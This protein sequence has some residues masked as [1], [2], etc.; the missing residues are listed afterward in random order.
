MNGRVTVLVCGDTMRGD[1]GLGIRA[2]AR[3]PAATS[4][5]AEIREIGQLSP[6]DL[7]DATGPVI[8][9]DAV[10]G[11]PPGEL[12]DMPLVELAGSA[13]HP[14]SP[15]THAL[16][17]ATAV[18]LCMQLRGAVPPGRFL[19]LAGADFGIGA[20]LSDTVTEA[21]PQLTT[22]IERWIGA[23]AHPAALAT[24]TTTLEGDR[25]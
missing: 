9:V 16:P 7:L 17:L 19:G 1:D 5:L 18:A 14:L 4:E 3:L 25:A 6:D 2:A 12:L 20:V 21:L 8:V 24:A 22:A 10:S 11:P 13:P 15:S 23:L